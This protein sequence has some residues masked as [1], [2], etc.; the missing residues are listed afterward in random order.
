MPCTTK[1]DVVQ[2]CYEDGMFT[3]GLSC[4]ETLQEY[5][6]TIIPISTGNLKIYMQ[7]LYT[8][9]LMTL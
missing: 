9:L 3:G 7:Q 5:G 6:C 4:L 1:D 2:I 8:T